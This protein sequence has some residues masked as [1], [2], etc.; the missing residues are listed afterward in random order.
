M[1]RLW[2][3]ALV[4]LVGALAACNP[5]AGASTV[6]ER[7][8]ADLGDPAAPVVVPD[9]LPDG[10]EY[11]QSSTRIEDDGDVLAATW[12]Y[13]PVDGPDEDAP[14]VELCVVRPP[15]TLDEA[16]SV[17]H[18]PL[19]VRELEGGIEVAVVPIGPAPAPDDV[20]ALEVWRDVD[21]TTEWRSASWLRD[22]SSGS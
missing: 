7:F 16:C 6:A 13:R 15:V 10:Y 4:L 2:M 20:P 3:G 8:E 5:L 18:T 14:V 1:G 21:L 17:S 19:L 12:L 11:W 22:P 9:P